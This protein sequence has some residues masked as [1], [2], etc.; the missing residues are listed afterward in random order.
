MLGHASQAPW[1]CGLVSAALLSGGPAGTAP[2]RVSSLSPLLPTSSF[3]LSSL[4]D[5]PFPLWHIWK[6]QLIIDCGLVS[7]FCF[8]QHPR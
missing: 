7:I 3:F 2:W 6:L 4:P 5:R 1:L 8:R